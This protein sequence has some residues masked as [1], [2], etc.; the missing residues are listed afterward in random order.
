MEATVAAL[1]F[2][3]ATVVL[4]C[5]AVVYSVEMVQQTFAGTSPQMKMLNEIQSS[6]LNQ[7]SAFNGTSGFPSGSFEPSPT[8]TA[9]P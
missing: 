8:P 4:S 2:V 5:V 6:I 1:L 7:T 9:A 3:T